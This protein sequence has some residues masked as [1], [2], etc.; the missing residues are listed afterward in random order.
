MS[1]LRLAAMGDR[2]G[3]VGV[4]AAMMGSILAGVGTFAL[5]QSHLHYRGLL[6]R[7][8]TQAAALAG[9][10]TISSAISGVFAGFCSTMS[11]ALKSVY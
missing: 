4:M 10:A 9:A 7:H 11:S 5:D 1:G 6:Q 2:R 3:S 8:A